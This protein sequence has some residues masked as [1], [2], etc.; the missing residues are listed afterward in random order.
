MDLLNKTTQRRTLSA[1]ARGTYDV[2]LASPPCTTFSRASRRGDAGPEPVRSARY[3]R[4]F[5]WLGPRARKSVNNANN[6]IDFTVKALKLQAT[7]GGILLES[8]EDL[9][10]TRSERPASILEM[11]WRSCPPAYA[12][13][14]VWCLLPGGFR[15]GLPQAIKVATQHSVLWGRVLCWATQP[16]TRVAGTQ[17]R[18]SK[19]C[20][21]L[22]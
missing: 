6:L 9:G 15:H 1:I 12:R 17:G 16:S 22:C 18:S 7:L 19:G 14:D 8:P 10:R 5:P 21:P 2:V 4:G 20:R 3:P 13:R 11:A